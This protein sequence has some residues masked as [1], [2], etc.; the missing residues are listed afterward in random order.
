M[1]EGVGDK[2]LADTDGPEHD[3]IALCLHEAKAHK[4]LQDATVVGDLGG[5]V[6]ALEHHVIDEAGVVGSACG[7]GIAP[8]LD[9]IGEQPEQEVLQRHLVLLGESEAL[10]ESGQDLA[11]TQLF[12]YLDELGANC[13]R[14]HHSP[15]L[16]VTV[17]KLL[18]GRAK[19][20]VGSRI[21]LPAGAASSADCA[22]LSMRSSRGTSMTSNTRERLQRASTLSTP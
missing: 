17:A 12:H 4:L 21:T 2:G 22:F 18:G 10:G 9:L 8:P 13:F 14:G 6:P 15:P 7:G 5:L 3:D 16:G 11:E 20:L 1:A 19:R